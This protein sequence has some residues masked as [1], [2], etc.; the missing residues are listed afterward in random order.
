MARITVEDCLARVESRFSLVILAAKR[1]KMLLKGAPPLVATD[2]KVIVNAL[3]EI[4]A[5]RVSYTYEPEGERGEAE[6][7]RVKLIEKDEKEQGQ[8]PAG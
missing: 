4:A 5:G 2:N 1:A 7:P 3:R 8:E 6:G